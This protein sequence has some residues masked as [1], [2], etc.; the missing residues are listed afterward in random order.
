MQTTICALLHEQALFLTTRS[1]GFDY[2]ADL[3][4]SVEQ[5]ASRFPNPQI[6]L[7]GNLAGFS[8]RHSLATGWEF[9]YWEDYPMRRHFYG[10]CPGAGLRTTE[11][12]VFT[13]TLHEAHQTIWLK[14]DSLR[15]IDR[16]YEH[17]DG[18][19]AQV[20]EQGQR[21]DERSAGAARIKKE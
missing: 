20:W 6:A 16:I 14:I 2:P 3:V 21:L 4:A 8:L 17:I 1:T 19:W 15:Y 9:V 13:L 18:N 10:V 7:E 12:E 5:R 11:V